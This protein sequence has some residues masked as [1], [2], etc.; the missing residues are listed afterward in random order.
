MPLPGTRA[1]HPRFHDSVRR[2]AAGEAGLIDKGTLTRPAAGAGTVSGGV[3][4]PAA[5]TTIGTANGP[6]RVQPAGNA[7]RMARFGEE[8]VTIARYVIGFPHD[9]VPQSGDS[10]V[11]TTCTGDPALVNRPMRI[12]GVVFDTFLAQRLAA[13][14]DDPEVPTP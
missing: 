4:T 3:W 5:P 6:C 7:E 11:A 8:A 1:V 9:V 14:T 13:A 10:F 2:S 12:V